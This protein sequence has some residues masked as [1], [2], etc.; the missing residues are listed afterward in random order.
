MSDIVWEVDTFTGYQGA[1]TL[2]SSGVEWVV[3]KSTGWWDSPPTRSTDVSRLTHGSYPGVVYKAQRVVSLSGM[4]TAPSEAAMYAAI[5]RV[6]AVLGDGLL[7]PLQ[8]SVDSDVRT[9]AVKLAENGIAV[10]PFSQLVFDYQITLVAPDPRKHG[11]AGSPSQGTLPTPA[12]GGL[13]AT[14][15]GLNATAPGLDAGTP[16]QLGFVQVTNTGT[17]PAYPLITFAGNGS[18]LPAPSLTNQATGD[19][20]TYTGTL[21]ANESVVINCDEFPY[22]GYPERSVLLQGTADRG[23]LLSIV[24]DWPV[25]PPGQS[26]TWLF[27]ATSYNALSTVTVELRPAYW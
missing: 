11:P 3:I 6:N 13:N 9:A 17:A 2:D 1:I 23:N 15:P 16:G 20:I 12:T 7:H 27:R 22:L 14:A 5:D 26:V 18:S 8:V 19:V 4:A 24:G 10:D 25:V 21:A